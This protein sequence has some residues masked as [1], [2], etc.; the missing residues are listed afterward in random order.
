MGNN[1]PSVSIVMP[2]LNAARTLDLCLA[3]IRSQDYPADLL[4]IIIADAG[5]DDATLAIAKNHRVDKIIKNELITGEAGKAAGLRVAAKEIVALIDSDNILPST[6]WLRRMVRPFAERDIFGAEPLE[7]TRR[8]EDNYITRYCALIGMNDPLVMF[9]GNYDRYNTITRKWTGLPVQTHDAGDYLKVTLEEQSI[10]TIGANGACLRRDVL[11]AIDIGDYLFDIDAVYQIV[12]LGHTEFAKVKI[13]IVHLFGG[14][15]ATF[16]RKQKRRIKDY[17]YFQKQGLR[18][19]PWK[20]TRSTGLARFI[21]YCVTVFPLVGQAAIGFV[22]VPDSAWFFH[23][24]AC[25][26]T[27]W[28]YGWG[29][30]F[31]FI[32]PAIGSRNNWSQ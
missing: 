8:R 26:I 7:Y 12:K 3:S 10:P 31:G 15:M 29:K 1:L 17:T 21:I 2:T 6:D 20:T 14:N 19:Y 5:S 22:R 30:I 11:S 28:E 23:P 24:I 13:G 4:E 16:A 27:L 32:R 9:L 25:W 18:T